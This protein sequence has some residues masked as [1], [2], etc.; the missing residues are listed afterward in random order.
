VAG[1]D[2]VASDISQRLE[3]QGGVVVEVNAGPGLAMQSGT[4]RSAR[5]GPWGEAIVDTTFSRRARTAGI[6]NRVCDR[7]Q[8]QDHGDPDWLAHILRERAVWWA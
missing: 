2:I 1:L 6:P 7:H 8:R 3:D 5:P 4:P